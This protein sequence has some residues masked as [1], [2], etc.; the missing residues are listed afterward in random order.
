MAVPVCEPLRCAVILLGLL[1]AGCLS[2]T[3]PARYPSRPPAGMGASQAEQERLSCVSTAAN[4]ASERSW[5]YV[6]CLIS[7]GHTV[8][9]AFAI[10]GWRTYFDVTQT[11]PHGA[12]VVVAELE[13][14]RR[15]A[16]AAGRSQG[17]STY[18]GI[19]DEIETAFRTCAGGRGYSVE[20][21][22]AATGRP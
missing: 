6:G 18:S 21:N 7:K 14:C 13:E 22:V 1:A 5:A 11:Q 19:A 4:V 20:R 16:Y 15:I 12:Q 9:V 3:L 17:G 8:G 10:Q 2:T